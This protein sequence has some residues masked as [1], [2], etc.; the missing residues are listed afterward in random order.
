MPSNISGINQ[1]NIYLNTITGG[2][3]VEITSNNS[4]QSTVNL[5]P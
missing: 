3:A 2:E 4:T 5:E 1:S